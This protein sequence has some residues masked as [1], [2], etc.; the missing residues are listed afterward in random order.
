[1]GGDLS[2]RAPVEG[3]IGAVEQNPDV[4]VVLVGPSN[5]LRDLMGTYR[6]HPRLLVR[7]ADEIIGMDEAPV[8]AVRR[9]KNS[10]MVQAML[11]VK[12]GAAHAVISAGNTGALMA[13]GLLILGRIPGVER[14]ALS[15]ILPSFTSW[16]VL[17]LDV[18]ANMDPKP[19]HLFQYALMGSLY[20]QEAL[21]IQRPRVGLLNVGEEAGKGPSAIREVYKR[22]KESDLEFIGNVEAR[23]VLQGSADILVCEGF[24]GNV[25]LKL[26]EGLARDFMKQLKG[27]IVSSVASRMAGLVLK[28]GLKRLRGML[29][30]QDYGGAPLL[31]LDEVVYKC[32]G[33]SKSSAF[34]A[35]ILAAENYGKRFAHQRIRERLG[36]TAEGVNG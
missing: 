8:A 3:A 16:G 28:P 2:P 27:M 11:A 19:I 4:E 31:G 15:A 33:S 18:G 17:V 26:T 25:V 10:S 35:A 20:C 6:D 36:Q 34:R 1:M 14:P 9:K 5:R 29:D 32:H 22:L 24:V 7:P 21:D 12:E 13:S 30:Y 23:E